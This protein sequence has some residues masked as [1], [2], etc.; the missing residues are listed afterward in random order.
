MSKLKIGIENFTFDASHYTK[1]ISEKCLNIHGHTFRV[2]VEIEGNIDPSTG[3]IID[4]GIIKK[5]VKE[6]LDDFD[7][8]LIVPQKDLGKIRLEGPFRKDIKVIKYPEAT[9]EY[10]ALAIGEELF[11]KLRMPVKVKVYEG[12]KNYALAE[13]K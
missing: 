8:K 12:F 11:K 6:I 2:N 5:V 7:H 3:M 13:F 9:T 4:F 10:I 1:G